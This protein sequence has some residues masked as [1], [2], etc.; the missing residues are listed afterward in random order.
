MSLIKGTDMAVILIWIS[1]ALSSAR[2]L[3]VSDFS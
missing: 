2:S 3:A 1:G